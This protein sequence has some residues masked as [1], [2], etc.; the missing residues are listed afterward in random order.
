[1]FG[2]TI[3]E[4]VDSDVATCTP[5]ISFNIFSLE[6]LRHETVK[7]PFGNGIMVIDGSKWTHARALIQSSFD[8]A[9]IIVLAS[10]SAHVDPLMGLIP[11]DGLTIDL[12]PLFKR[13]SMHNANLLMIVLRIIAL[14]PIPSRLSIYLA[15]F[16]LGTQSSPYHPPLLFYPAMFSSL[17]PTLKEVSVSQHC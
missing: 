1:M 11:G 9:P 3:V 4:T 7:K 2:T 10:L 16:I 15:I 13:P 6:P 14:I 5:T 8:T 17:S 12:L